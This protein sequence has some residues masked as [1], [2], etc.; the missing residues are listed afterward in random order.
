MSKIFILVLFALSLPVKLL[1]AV[2]INEVAWMGGGS[3]ANHEWIELRNDDTLAVSVA[4]WTLGDGSNLEI[5]LAGTIDSNA[6]A[7]LERSSDESA[8]GP[9]FLIYTGALVNTGATLT[10]RNDTGAIMDQ[11]AGGENWQE[12]GGDNVTKETAQYTSRGWVTAAATPGLSNA[13][14]SPSGPS[15]TNTS[16]T[17]T[18]RVIESSQATSSGIK[19]KSTGV[20]STVRLGSQNPILKLTVDQHDIAYVNQTTS[21]KVT[22]SGVGDTIAESL[23]YTWNFG[24]SLTA[25]GTTV[26]H[27]YAYPGTYV[28]TVRAVY[29][30]N[31]VTE[32]R[33]ITILPATFSITRNEFGDVQLNNDAPYD[34][35]IS[36][37]TLAGTSNVVLPARSLMV[38]RGTVTIASERLE[39]IPFGSEITL[40]D[41][42][43]QLV[44]STLS[45]TSSV[46]LPEV[47]SA[48]QSGEFRLQKEAAAVILA[49]R[50]AP[51]V[52]VVPTTALS[53]TTEEETKTTVLSKNNPAP[54]RWPYIALIVV[55]LA[56]LL[57]VGSKKLVVTK[58]V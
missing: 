3:S 29:A 54:K 50:V 39:K 46:A 5:I 47:S 51:A 40:H 4:G 23:V 35:D 15:G 55:L 31:D 10:L 17:S 48:V 22:P 58:G 36:G 30:K 9:A 37:Y 34:I 6:Y 1:A 19:S 13:A 33:E 45:A 24:D 8:A 7:V 2:T 16:S 42:K 32:R 52:S 25:T 21:F 27:H 43:R 57:V 20:K 18:P 11:V 53:T 28:V 26:S 56:A 44:A 41:T 49:E 12:I 14:V 38:A